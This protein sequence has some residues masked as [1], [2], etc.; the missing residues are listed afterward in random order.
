MNPAEARAD[1][2]AADEPDVEA[3]VKK[4]WLAESVEMN[5]EVPGVKVK[6]KKVRIDGGDNGREQRKVQFDPGLDLKK[7]LDGSR[8]VFDP[9]G[10]VVEEC[11]VPMFG[12]VAVYEI[13]KLGARVLRG[14]LHQGE[15]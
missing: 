6:H 5:A 10:G 2:S 9:G 14:S 3:E 7:Q 8:T 13:E 11:S 12:S 15:G 1:A 4:A